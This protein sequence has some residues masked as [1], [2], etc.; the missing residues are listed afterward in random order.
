MFKTKTNYKNAVYIV[1][2]QEPHGAGL[3][4]GKFYT[5]YDLAAKVLARDR[6]HGID[7]T[8]IFTLYEEV[9]EV[10]DEHPVTLAHVAD[11]QQC[12]AAVSVRK[13]G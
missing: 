2:I 1:A 3:D 11:C 13:E 6:E 4:S 8:R 7:F 5:R 9:E 10:E 12:S